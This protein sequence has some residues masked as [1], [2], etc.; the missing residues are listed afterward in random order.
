MVNAG[1]PVVYAMAVPTRNQT[2][3]VTADALYNN[4]V[5]H[6]GFP[7]RLHSDQGANFE[8][9]VI[10]ELC[11]MAGV[12]KS[13][14]T[15]YNPSGNGITERMNRTLLGMLGTLQPEQKHDWKARIN[16]L[17]HAY[18]CCRHDTTGY[19]P[20]Q[21]MFGRQPRLAIDVVLGLVD[22]EVGRRRIGETKGET[23]VFVESERA[24]C[25]C[26]IGLMFFIYFHLDGS[27]SSCQV[28]NRTGFHRVPRAAHRCGV[29]HRHLSQF[30]D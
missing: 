26:C 29:R 10:K 8:S 27:R 19:S 9:T 17:V 16:H 14:T 4:F 7:R 18:N 20:Y 23:V 2:A 28:Q 6:Y 11:A 22:E 3:K 12:T 5:A 25:K 30:Y 21:L 15:P 24:G 1:F 13:R